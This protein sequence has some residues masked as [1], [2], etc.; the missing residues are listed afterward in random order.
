MQFIVAWLQRNVVPK[1]STPQVPVN[2]GV[3]CSKDPLGRTHEH[4]APGKETIRAPCAPAAVDVGRCRA[5]NHPKIFDGRCRCGT[6]V[7]DGCGLGID[8]RRIHCPPAPPGKGAREYENSR[9]ARDHPMAEPVR[10][11]RKMRLRRWHLRRW[12]VS[13]SRFHGRR[14]SGWRLHRWGLPLEFGR[15]GP[16]RQ[17][18]SDRMVRTILGEV[19]L[20]KLLSYLIGRHTDDGVLTRIEVLRKL[21]EFYTD[22]AFFESAARTANR[23]LDD[24]LKELPASLARAKRRTLQRRLSS[25]CTARSWDSLSSLISFLHIPGA[26]RESYHRHCAGVGMRDFNGPANG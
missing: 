9:G 2:V 19:M 25:A 10:A 23:V 15:V 3:Q 22:R 1:V 13:G 18:D 7:K 11:C 6:R 20:S 8:R 17:A 5:R 4:V 12:R 24:V 21:E 14:L 26:Q 16:W